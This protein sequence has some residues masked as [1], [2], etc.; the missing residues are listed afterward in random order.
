MRALKNYNKWREEC[1][2]RDILIQLDVVRRVKGVKV[3][4]CYVPANI[5][6]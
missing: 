6:W 2:L 4:L 3:T 5:E 1:L